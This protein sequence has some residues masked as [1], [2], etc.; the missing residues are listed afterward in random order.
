VTATLCSDQLVA[1]GQDQVADL[2]WPEAPDQHVVTAHFVHNGVPQSATITGWLFEVSGRICSSGG[3]YS[4]SPATAVSDLGRFWPPPRSANCATSGEEI[5]VRFTTIEFGR[6][7]TSFNWNGADTE[8]QVETGT[9]PP[10]PTPTPAP[11]YSSRITIHSLLRGVPLLGAPLPG[12]ALSG[13]IVDGWDCGRMVLAVIG[14]AGPV[15]VAG[16][17]WH[18]YAPCNEVGVPVKICVSSDQT[19]TEGFIFQGHDMDV[20]MNWPEIPYLH[21]VTAHFVR[22]G[23]PQS[24]TLTGWS[25]DAGVTFNG[26]VVSCS[27]GTTPPVILSDVITPWYGGQYCGGDV[28]ARFTTAEFGELSGTFNWVG[29][30]DVDYDVVVPAASPS[31]SQSP[32]PTAVPTMAPV[33]PA[34]LPSAGGPPAGGSGVAEVMTVLAAVTVGAGGWLI[35]RRRTL[36][37]E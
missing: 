21:T 27:S 7:T 10:P 3:I 18:D 24:V 25:I 12:S 2:N 34:A 33:T 30:A 36:L 9:S 28:H 5:D 13:A 17:P 19:C 26:Q 37:P 22:N 1:S 35:A 31:T 29:N 20:D 6:L 32:V 14:E 11:A 16:W 4:F 23:V 8:Y 15:I